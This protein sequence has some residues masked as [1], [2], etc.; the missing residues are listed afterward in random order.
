MRLLGY[1]TAEG[2]TTRYA[3]ALVFNINETHLHADVVD[4]FK[5]IFN[6]NAHIR[7]RPETASTCITVSSPIIADFFKTHTGTGAHEKH[8]PEFI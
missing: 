4:L 2:R 3:T 7:H 8:I 5:K 6:I 1:Y